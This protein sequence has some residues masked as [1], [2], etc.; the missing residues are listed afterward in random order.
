MSIFY[1]I[2][3]S[4]KNSSQIYLLIA[5]LYLY[6]YNYTLKRKIEKYFSYFLSIWMK[7][8]F[9]PKIEHFLKFQNFVE[10]SNASLKNNSIIPKST[11]LSEYN[12]G[13]IL[14]TLILI[15]LFF[16]EIRLHLFICLLS[17]YYQIVNFLYHS[18]FHIT[19]ASCKELKVL[20]NRLPCISVNMLIV[21][22]F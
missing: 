3:I 8:L 17:H 14:Y 13:C 6:F 1:C 7:L 12:F 11:R 5:F 21:I 10:C 22:L 4:P 18:V 20:F 16:I 2:S 9:F 19:L 15:S